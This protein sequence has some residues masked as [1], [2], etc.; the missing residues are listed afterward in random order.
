VRTV[1]T[2]ASEEKIGP[3]ADSRE[4]HEGD[5]AS[6]LFV[7]KKRLIPVVVLSLA[8]AGYFGWGAWRRAQ[9]LEWS[10]TVE[11]RSIRVGSR[12][13]GR[14]KDVLV[15]E[16]DNVGAGQVLVNLEPG[17]LPAQ[18]LIAQGQL[19]QAQANLDKLEKGAR[20]EEIEAAKAR[21]VTAAAALEESKTGARSEQLAAANARLVA[22]QVAVDKAQ[23]DAARARKLIATQAISQAE[24]D[25][26]ESALRGAT[27]QRDAAQQAYDELKNGVRREEIAQATARA[28]EA[29]ASAQ[30]VVAGSRVEDIRAARGMVEAAQGRLDQIGIMID[31]LAIKAARPARV[32]ALD[33]RPGDLLNPNATAVTLVEADQ[34]YVR[35][36]VPETQI[37]K[38]HPNDEVPVFVDSFPDKPFKGVVEHIASVGEFS[39]RNLQTADERADQVFL[40]R[41]GVRESASLRAGMAAFVRVRP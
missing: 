10:G 23:I 26:A 41:V 9:P 32:E 40:A 17:D 28:A 11:A 15:R 37:G 31:E 33:L 34:L 20:P 5:L 19:D 38:L 24:L 13:G 22:A 3:D 21:A 16:G 4:T 6:L 2:Q 18:K 29:R 35:I 7:E 14:V 30:L 8:A 12:T 27:A 25:N 1:V 39:P 36:Y